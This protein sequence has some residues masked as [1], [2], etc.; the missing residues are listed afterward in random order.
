MSEVE[1]VVGILE[2]QQPRQISA[3][4]V[5]SRRAREHVP[6]QDI[7]SDVS[8][9]K[10][11]SE[12]RIRAEAEFIGKEPV[13]SVVPPDKPL[14]DY[15]TREVGLEGEALAAAYLVKRGY[16]IIDRNWRCSAGEV[17]IVA[18]DGSD[19]VLVEVKTRA[20]RNEK[21]V[22]V[23]ELAVGMKKQRTYTHL[24]LMYVGLHPEVRNIRFDV[25]AIVLKSNHSAILRHLVGAFCWD[26]Q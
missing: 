13:F 19:V 14:K 26:E 1:K 12:E 10:S 6:T 20:Q 22:G 24:A 17:D 11:V 18:Q 25:I 4:K 9:K 16:K 15:S 2:G 5:R 7:P 3:K 21:S 8:D 23:P